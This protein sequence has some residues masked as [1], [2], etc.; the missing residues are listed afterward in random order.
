M[1]A[2]DGYRTLLALESLFNHTFLSLTL[3]GTPG[4]PLTPEILLSS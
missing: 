4:L 2:F 3:D 1:Q